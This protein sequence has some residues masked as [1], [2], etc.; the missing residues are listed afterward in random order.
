MDSI[1]LLFLCMITGVA[2][3]YSKAFP[4]N[5]YVTLNQFVIHISLPALALYYIPKIEI[6]SQLLFPLG[7]AWIGFVLSYLFFTIFGKIFGWSRKL[8]GCLILM[9]GLGNTSFVGFPV[10]EALYGKPGLQ[11]AIVVDQPGSFMVMATLGIIVAAQFSRG[12][13]NPK[14]ILF[15]IITFPPFIAFF[16]AI[17][18]NVL[19]V[20]FISNLQSVFQ[21]LGNTV[22]PIALVAVGLQLKFDRRSKHY[23]FLALGLFFKLM[24]TPAFFYLLYKLFFNQHNLQIDVSIMEAAMAPMITASVLATTY[25]LKPKLSTMMIGI[26]I[27]LSFVTLAFWYWILITF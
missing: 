10:I 9:S 23:N 16:I 21:K 25:G 20:D 6:N 7:I 24:I 17:A 13:P 11:T 8:I 2:L 27:P 22:T 19:K 15:K 12:T 14:T 18:M 1:I 5:S 4:A 3:Q 26:G